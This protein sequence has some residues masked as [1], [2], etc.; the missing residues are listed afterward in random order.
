MI[1]GMGS[2]RVLLLETE[3]DTATQA[4]EAL[5]GGMEKNVS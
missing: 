2:I 3:P 1:D 5:A 4:R